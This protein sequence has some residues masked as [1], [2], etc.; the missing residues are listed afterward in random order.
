MLMLTQF[1]HTP[2]CLIEMHRELDPTFI[3][4]V[5]AFTHWLFKAWQMQVHSHEAEFDSRK[6]AK[7]HAR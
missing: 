4:P 2:V 1:I 3:W 6:V 7:F 5:G